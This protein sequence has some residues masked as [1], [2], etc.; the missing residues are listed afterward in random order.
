MKHYIKFIAE[1]IGIICECVKSYYKQ[2]IIAVLSFSSTFFIL[3]S[4]CAYEL[5]NIETTQFILQIIIGLLLAVLFY[6]FCKYQI[7]LEEKEELIEELEEKN[8]HQFDLKIAEAFEEYD[9]RM[10]NYELH[11]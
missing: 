9:E 8:N 1:K 10:R 11:R 4:V 6:L 5:E 2:I 7:A 3:G